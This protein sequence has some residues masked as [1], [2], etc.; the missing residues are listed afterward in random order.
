MNPKFR[1]A[2][3]SYEFTNEVN[4]GI[5]VTVQDQS[6]SISDLLELTTVYNAERLQPVPDVPYGTDLTD[7]YPNIDELGVTKPHEINSD[8]DNQ[9]PSDNENTEEDNIRADGPLGNSD[10]N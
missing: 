2:Y 8:T 1:S 4:S 3:E 9:K 10:K 5:E 7:L 6:L